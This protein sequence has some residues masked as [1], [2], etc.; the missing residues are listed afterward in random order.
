MKKAGRSCGFHCK[1]IWLTIGLISLLFAVAIFAGITDFNNF[2][3]TGMSVS[4]FG[5]SHVVPISYIEKGKNYHF[6]VQSIYGVDEVTLQAKETLKN[7]ILIFKEDSSIDFGENYISKFTISSESASKIG[8][9]DFLLK[10]KETDFLN[11]GINKQDLILYANGKEMPVV[12]KKTEDGYSLFTAT[13]AGLGEFVIG[14]AASKVAEQK[15]AVPSADADAAG[16]TS[17]QEAEEIP[18]A[19]AEEEL[20]SEPISESI[21][22][23]EAVVEKSVEEP[24]SA[25]TETDMINYIKEFF[26]GL[27]GY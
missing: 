5:G 6:E 18:Q 19:A 22:D 24:S 11:K 4:T 27:F 7:A 3:S 12:F 2:N 1:P 16:T 9:V 8:N 10:I 15:E 21:K 23:S 20:P 13:S 26:R 14:R 25:G 17:S